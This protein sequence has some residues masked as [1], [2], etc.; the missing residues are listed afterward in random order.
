MRLSI[1]TPCYNEAEN[2]EEWHRQLGAVVSQIESDIE[3]VF[4]DE[5]AESA[6]DFAPISPEI[7]GIDPLYD[8]T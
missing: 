7:P 8:Q 2:I 5:A 6:G 3:F 4:V 1:V